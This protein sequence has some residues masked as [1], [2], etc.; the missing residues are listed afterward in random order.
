MPLQLNV[1]AELWVTFPP[2]S[3]KKGGK[4]KNPRHK[5]WTAT[6]TSLQSIKQLNSLY[7]LLVLFNVDKDLASHL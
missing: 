4:K 6:E 1:I 3:G 7:Q 5:L 2:A